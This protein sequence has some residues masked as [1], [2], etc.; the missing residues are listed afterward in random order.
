MI[1]SLLARE[2]IEWLPKDLLNN[3]IV[4]SSRIRLARNL[5][6][7]SFPSRIDKHTQLL[8]FDRVVSAMQKNIICPNPKII[9]LSELDDIDRGFL[10]ERHLISHYH[11]TNRKGEPGIVFYTGE[12]AISVMINEEDH[13]RVQVIKGGLM[14]P[15]AWEALNAA[16]DELSQNLEFAYDPQYG[17]L[18]ACPTNTGTGMRVS[19]LVHLP[20]LVITDEI[21][22]LVNGLYKIGFSMRGFYGEGTSP[23]GAI[24]QV[25]NM[26]TL[27][28]RE[29]DI[30]E[31]MEKVIMTII[32][33][34]NE[35]R[36]NLLKNKYIQEVEDKVYRSY[37]VLK[38]AR[39]IDTNEMISCISMVRLGI[40]L[41]FE[42]PVSENTIDQ[43]MIMF[44]SAHLQELAGKELPVRQRDYLRAEL[45][46]KNMIN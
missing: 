9:K 13:L 41:G 23:T 19:C 39:S 6:G 3:G 22:K 31:E 10:M 11:A 43:S 25:S 20:G 26:V 17:Y 38:F 18:T 27:G 24:F 14:L 16:D 42:L 34:E 44:Q 32:K 15:Q 46:R 40:M 45:I 29:E 7:I 4:I 2:K 35:A 30:V 33:Y 1:F 37:G 28:K 21:K 12:E 8:V 36:K 5:S